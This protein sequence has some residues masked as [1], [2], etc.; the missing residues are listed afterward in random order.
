MSYDVGVD[1]ADVGAHPNVKGLQC[2]MHRPREDVNPEIACVVVHQ[3]TAMGGCAMTTNDVCSALTTR[4]L[5]AVAFDLRGAGSSSGSCC[6]WPIPLVS[7]CPEVSDV[8]TVCDWVFNTL[9]R[10]VWIVGVSAGG[11]IGG[12]A[13]DALPSIRGYCSIA[14]TFGLATSL[15]WG[16]HSLRLLISPKPKLFISGGHDIFTSVSAF[17]MVGACARRPCAAVLVPKAGHFDLEYA[18]YSHLNADLIS[19]FIQTAGQSIPDVL[20]PG[21]THLSAVGCT[22][23]MRSCLQ[24]GPLY[25]LVIMGL[26]IWLAAVGIA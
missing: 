14:C 1:L 12:G 6:M 23:I 3:C 5:L 9:H 4:G 22:A 7:G 21:A 19:H 20:P 26:L 24:C 17:K 2:Y 10:D 13:I 15:L 25:I 16:T 18:P 8:V 11:P